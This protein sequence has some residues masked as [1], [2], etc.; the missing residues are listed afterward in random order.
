[1]LILILNIDVLI[2]YYRDKKEL[3]TVQA[4]AAVAA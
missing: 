2:I 3:S 1:M 4:A